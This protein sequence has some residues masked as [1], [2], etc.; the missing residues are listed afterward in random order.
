MERSGPESSAAFDSF[1]ALKK[2]CFFD[3]GIMIDVMIDERERV[4]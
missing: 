2:V 3:I 4:I 1:M